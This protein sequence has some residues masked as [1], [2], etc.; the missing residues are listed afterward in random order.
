M[1]RASLIYIRSPRSAR[2]TVETLCQEEGWPGKSVS[3]TLPVELEQVHREAYLRI[4]QTP[5]SPGGFQVQLQTLWNGQE[6]I[7]I[8]VVLVCSSFLSRRPV[9]VPQLL[10]RICFRKNLEVKASDHLSIL[11]NCMTAHRL[12]TGEQTPET[13]SCLT[14]HEAAARF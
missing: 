12:H 10:S 9:G 5:L 3:P 14:R 6:E 8:C 2:A 4:S 13:H 11:L 1:L 7:F